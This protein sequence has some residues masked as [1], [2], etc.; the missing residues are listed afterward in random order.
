MIVTWP[1]HAQLFINVLNKTLLCDPWF[2]EPVFAGAWFRYPPSPFGDSSMF[3]KPD[4]VLLSHTHPDHAGLETLLQL[5][6]DVRVL[7]VDFPTGA[8]RRRVERAGLSDV[9]WVN[10]WERNQ[11]S[12][13]LTVTFVPNDQGWEVAAMVI[14]AEGHRVYHGNG[15]PLSVEGYKEVVRRLGA[16]ELA[17]LP[18]AG[19]SSY[20][21]GFF[22][23]GSGELSSACGL[24][25]NAGLKRFIDGLE[26]LRAAEA[27]P[28]ASSWALLETTE[29]QKNFVDRFSGDEVLKLAAVKANEAGTKL[30]HMEP[31]DEWSPETG[32]IRKEL[33][34]EW[35][36]T[37]QGVERYASQEKRRVGEAILAARSVGPKTAPAALHAAFRRYLEAMVA[38]AKASSSTLAAGFKTSGGGY[39]LVFTSG[40]KPV[41]EAG[42]QGDEDEVFSLDENELAAIVMGPMTWEDVWYGYRLQVTKRAGSEHFNE[43]YDLLLGFDDETISGTLRR[44]LAP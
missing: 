17:F 33:T 11:L 10:P 29:V 12:P 37:A 41:V 6:K 21:T 35:P 43:L 3:P 19:A 28:F 31:G 40:S 16:I 27:V 5:R 8:M 42:L 30:L 25:K 22:A 1:G 44:E 4:F 7:A 2:C 18:Y 9:Q 39:R 15:N 36:S 26:G 24:K 34:R 32:V 14:E 13:G 20:P 38:S 23:P